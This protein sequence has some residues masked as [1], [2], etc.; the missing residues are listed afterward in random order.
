MKQFCLNLEKYN[1]NQVHCQ[2][3]NVRDVSNRSKIERKGQTYKN[4]MPK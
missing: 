3:M 2:E 1:K 4:E